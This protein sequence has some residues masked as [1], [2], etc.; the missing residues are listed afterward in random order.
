MRYWSVVAGAEGRDYTDA[1][2]K[3]GLAFVGHKS[4]PSLLEKVHTGDCL[5]LR[6]GTS[7]IVAVGLAVERNGA[8]CGE[9]DKEWLSDFDGWELPYYRY[10]DWHPLAKASDRAR[11]SR[12][13]LKKVRK[14]DLRQWAEKVLTETP[15]SVDPS[16]EPGSTREVTDEEILEFLIKEGLRPGSAEDLTLALRRIRL[17]A[18]YY[19]KNC[20]WA[21]I[22]EHE[23]RTFLV[24]PLLLALGW[25]EQQ[26][27]VELSVPGA[28]GRIDVACFS[29]PYRRENGTGKANNEDCTVII[30]TKGFRSGL[31]YVQKQAKA[32]ARYFP[33]CEALAVSNGYCY[34]VYKRDDS[35]HF[36]EQP[37]AYLNL[38]HPRDRY[39]LDPTNVD[40]A[41]GVLKFLLPRSSPQS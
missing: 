36:P 21:D 9:G 35:G 8:A 16:P 15:A 41:F 28:G 31:D 34:K 22:R 10:V 30:E 27:K 11:F 32:Y 37:H 23:T 1:F 7:Q 5:L 38:L 18:R 29:R 17:L 13:T 24:M 33:L 20:R 26:L 4:G 19:Y 6:K 25:A 3:Y 39:P 14:A 40:G 2:L 12:G